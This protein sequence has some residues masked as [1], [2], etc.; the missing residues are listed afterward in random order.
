M[1]RVLPAWIALFGRFLLSEIVLEYLLW[2]FTRSMP[3]GLGMFLFNAAV[4]AAPPVVFVILGLVLCLPFILS[5]ILTTIRR[6][7]NEGR[8]EKR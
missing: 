8:L 1:E 5:R 3:F 7:H 4:N 2:S 6:A